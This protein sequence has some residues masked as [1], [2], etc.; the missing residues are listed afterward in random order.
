MGAI[1]DAIGAYAQPLVD[2]TDG[3]LEQLQKALNL[4]MICW[5]LASLPTERREEAIDEMQ[6]S[7]GMDDTEFAEFRR[8]LLVPM[9]VRRHEMFPAA[10]R[11][12]STGGVTVERDEPDEP[13]APQQSTLT[14]ARPRK[15]YPVDDRYGPCPCNSGQKYKFCC[16]K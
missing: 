2:A 10:Q 14:L 9:I 1:G 13:W 8:A 15:K 12:G 6:P 11:W 5:N 3:S 4:S 16:G 7:L